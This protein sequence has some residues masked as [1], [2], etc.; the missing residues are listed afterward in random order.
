MAGT[1][2][3]DAGGGAGSGG[4]GDG[5]YVPPPRQPDGE[6]PVALDKPVAG[7]DRLPSEDLR[8]AIESASETG[9]RIDVSGAYPGWD[10]V[11]FDFR[12]EERPPAVPFDPVVPA[13]GPPAEEQA[14]AAEGGAEAVA[15]AAAAAVGAVA[16]WRPAPLLV[17]GALA[18]LAGAVTGS[19]LAMLGGWGAIYLSRGLGD[20]TKKAVVLGVPL[21]CMTGSAVWAW[22]RSRGRWGEPLAQTGGDFGQATWA[23]AP[24]VLRAAAV[25]SAV[26]VVLLTLRRRAA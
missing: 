7:A 11:Y 24:G 20:F 18:L 21:A 1:W 15:G 13:E 26:V 19:I 5:V 17:V 6:P 25:V 2:W 9:R 8:R 3:S 22:G 14:G 16:G 23:S 4:D 12:A 10:T